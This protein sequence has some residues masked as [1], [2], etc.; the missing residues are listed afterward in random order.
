[1]PVR[2]R[3]LVAGLLPLLFGLS[4]CSDD[5]LQLEATEPAAPPSPQLSTEGSAGIGLNPNRNVYFGDTHVHTAYSFD[6]YL[7]GDT[8]GPDGAYRYAKGEAVTIATGIERQL[9][10]P[11]DFLAVSDHGLFLGVVPQWADPTTAVGQQPEAAPFHHVNEGDILDPASGLRRVALFREEF[12]QFATKPGSLIDRLEAK[13]QNHPALGYA[14]FDDDA[15]RRAWRETIDAAERHNHPG[16]FTAFLA[17]E[18]TASTPAPES[19]A[20]HRN[21]IFRGGATPKRPFTRLDSSN[22]EALWAWMDA[23]RARGV[24]T[25]AI[26]HNPN[27]SNGQMF[28]M[29]DT[30]GR[31]V[32][33]AFAETRMRNERLVEIT[34]IK[35]TSET[36]PRLSP[37]DEWAE[38]EI[39]NTRKGNIGQYSLPHGSYVRE[40]LINGLALQQEGRGNP[41]RMGFIGSSDAH[42]SAP[43]YDE[44]NYQG[45][46]VVTSSAE[47]RGAVPTSE[48]A[49]GQGAENEYLP[50]R[51]AQFAASGLAAVWAEANTRDAIFDAMRRKETY[52]TSGPR[53]KLRFFAGH[54]LDQLDVDDPGFIAAAYQDGV[55]MGGDLILA[56]DQPPHF[57]VWAQRDPQS[58]PLQRLQIIKGWY[59]GGHRRETR[60]AIYDVACSDGLAVGPDT[61]RCPDNG[62]AVNPADCGLTADTGASELKA[63]W[64]DPDHDPSIH[65]VYYVRVLENPT[66]RWSTWDAV[67]NGVPPRPGIPAVIQERAWSSPIWLAPNT[68]HSSAAEQRLGTDQAGS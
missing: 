23:L 24:E 21:L 1:M 55:P 46:A 40:A 28:R 67:R 62:A 25:L 14:A 66:C 18:W 52:A 45:S 41:F 8:L 31:P 27:Q 16:A 64:A 11:L 49:D 50:I 63:V 29:R 9:D 20:Y 44:W 6:A 17:Y 12:G 2:Q 53:I 5:T 68:S 34:Q 35:G 10:R 54:G 19:A 61:H 32:D 48:V 4:A 37:L 42:N 7:L 33:A 22:P 3:R 65:A 13:A 56:G 59:D 47:A 60:E 36:H 51:N 57:V 39:L 15:H 26:P 30:G 38:F 43:S 58:A